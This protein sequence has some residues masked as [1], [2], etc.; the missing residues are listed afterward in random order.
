MFSGIIEE[1]A[2]VKSLTQSGAGYRL[3][4]ECKLPHTDTAIGDSIAVNGCCLTVVVKDGNSLVFDLATETMRR[5]TM[6]ELKAGARVNVERSLRVGDRI[7][8]HFVTGHIDATSDLLERKKDGDNDRMLWSIAPPLKGLI[9]EKGSVTINGVSLTVGEVTDQHFA[10]YIIP[11]TLH[12]TNLGAIAV[13][14]SVNIEIDILARYVRSVLR[15]EK[16]DS[17]ISAEWLKL[18]GY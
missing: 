1:A 13:G 18:N 14:G 12:I 4:I 8:G 16:Q 15:G 6:G 17:G 10:V 11:H 5:T 7:S 3:T 2:Q 9:A